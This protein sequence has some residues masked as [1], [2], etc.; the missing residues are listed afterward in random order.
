MIADTIPQPAAPL[1]WS[2]CSCVSAGVTAKP[3]NTTSGLCSLCLELT[4]LTWRLGIWK[5]PAPASRF[6]SAE[7]GGA[8]RSVG[9]LPPS[10]LPGR[11][12][13]N[14]DL[15]DPRG[16][17]VPSPAE[18]GVRDGACKRRA[19]RSVAGS[20]VSASSM[21][22]P[23]VARGSEPSSVGAPLPVLGSAA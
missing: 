16:E 18:D 22:R 3:A 2:C 1:I 9:S 15:R 12:E 10:G 23:G 20:P 6:T 17:P 5:R 4:Y 14:A 8:S 7:E 11:R 21:G 19:Y 13:T